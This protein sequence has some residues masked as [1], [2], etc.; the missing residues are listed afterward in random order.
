M[1]W[2]FGTILIILGIFVL[3]GSFGAAPVGFWDAFLWII[4]I[5]FGLSGIFAM[6]RFFPRGLV[7]F[8]I[9]LALV[10]KLLGTI[11][12]GFWAFVGVVAGA[13][14]VQLGIGYM[15]GWGRFGWRRNRWRY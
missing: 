3:L 4:A 12:L 15:I 11:E 9:G 5:G 8:T 6:V 1:S 10:L 7:S 13:W 14:L 2:L